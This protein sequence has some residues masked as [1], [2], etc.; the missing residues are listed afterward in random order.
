MLVP[1]GGLVVNGA[2]LTLTYDEALDKAGV[3]ATPGEFLVRVRRAGAALPG[4]TV[5]GGKVSGDQ[6]VLTLSEPVRHGDRLGLGYAVPSDYPIRDLAGNRR[7]G[8][9][10]GAGSAS[11]TGRSPT[12]LPRARWRSGGKTVGEELTASVPDLADAD[13]LPDPSEFTWTWYRLDGATETEIAEATGMGETYKTYTLAPADAGK[14]VRA[15][16]RFR[17]GA[18]QPGAAGERGPSALRPGDVAGRRRLHGARPQ[19]QGADL[20]RRGRGG[21]EVCGSIDYHGYGSSPASAACRTPTSGSGRATTR[22]TVF[23]PSTRRCSSAWRATCRRRPRPRRGSCCMSATRR[24]SSA[25]ATEKA[26][27]TPLPASATPGSTASPTGR[28]TPTRRVWLSR[29]DTTA[30]MLVPPPDGVVA[31][32]AALTL[33]FD[34]QLDQDSEPAP[35]AFTLAVARPG[36][37]ARPVRV[38][39]V[40]LSGGEVVLT[41]SE[42]VRHGDTARLAYAAPAQNPL[43]DPAGNVAA[44]F[45]NQPVTVPANELAT[46]TVEISPDRELYTVGEDLTAT[47]SGVADADGLPD[48]IA[49]AYQ[50]L[51]IDGTLETPIDDMGTG[52]TKPT[53]WPGRC[54]QAGP[55]A[56]ALPR[57]RQQPGAAG[58][59]GAS[60]LRRVMWPVDPPVAT[61]AAVAG[62]TAEPDL[63]RRGDGE[64]GDPRRLHV[65][66]IQSVGWWVRVR[67]PD[68]PRFQV[69][70]RATTRSTS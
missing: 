37:A 39:G 5:T 70:E 42:P 26:F 54:R 45:G 49:Y 23:I 24:S 56:A 31:D 41:L 44:G 60:A 8:E 51:R 38:T 66:R 29:A 63:D 17:D 13:G 32:G 19:R 10:W 15:R 58:E 59:R 16:L 30:P 22:S 53:R 9:A 65:L 1:R 28:A 62:G 14:Q 52:E 36:A 61:P 12:T 34:E 43:Q 40:T 21:D 69:R 68:G 25:K 33:T 46:G 7:L 55:G 67:R 48:P 57:P 47:V 4:F 64:D 20:D 3:P 50:W 18:Q 6:V 11:P 2:T 35:G 27:T